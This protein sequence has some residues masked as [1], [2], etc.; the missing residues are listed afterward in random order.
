M[1]L[2]EWDT[3]GLFVVC[4]SGD[5]EVYLGAVYIKRQELFS[6]DLQSL[7]RF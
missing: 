7:F 2:Q 5:T 4:H 6:Q 1:G 3:L